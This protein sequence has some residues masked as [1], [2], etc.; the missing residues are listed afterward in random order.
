[1]NECC[2]TYKNFAKNKKQELKV[3][4]GDNIDCMLPSTIT[5]VEQVPHQDEPNYQYIVMTSD[6]YIDIF[7]LN[8]GEVTPSIT[9]I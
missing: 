1:V 8:T 5:Q 6:G 7:L 2:F 3:R 4:T 9:Y